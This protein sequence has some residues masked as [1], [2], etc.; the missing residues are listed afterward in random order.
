M[1]IRN[2]KNAV[3]CILNFVYYER[4]LLNKRSD[5]EVFCHTVAILTFDLYKTNAG[6]K[7][8]VEWHVALRYCLLVYS[9]SGSDLTF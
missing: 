6:N 9:R 7:I 5:L 4:M 2:C 3:S 8:P 1:W